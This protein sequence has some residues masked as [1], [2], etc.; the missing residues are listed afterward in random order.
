MRGHETKSS[1]LPAL[2]LVYMHRV[3]CACAFLPHCPPVSGPDDL[4]VGAVCALG[5]YA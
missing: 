2:L 1:D 4:L 5:I 3:V